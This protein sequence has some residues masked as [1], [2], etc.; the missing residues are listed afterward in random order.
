[1]ATEKSHELG[2]FVKELRAARQFSLGELARLAD[3]NKATLSRWEA[4]QRLPRLPELQAVM[5]ALGATPAQL[6]RAAALLDAPRGVRQLRA[7][8]QQSGNAF[9]EL[10]ERGP[11]GGDLL[12]AM[13]LRQAKGLE[14]VARAIGV[15]PS[16]LSRW[17]RGEVWP[18]TESLHRLCHV[19][20]VHEAEMVALTTGTFRTG[21]DGAGQEQNLEALAER[22]HIL[23]YHLPLQLEPLK[24]LVFF[25]LEAR[26]WP[27]A[28]H[29][30]KARQMLTYL[31]TI[32]AH[33]LSNRRRWAEIPP[34]VDRSMELA[35]LERLPVQF[36]FHAAMAAAQSAVYRGPQPTPARG[37]ALV[38]P[39]I[40]VSPQPALCAWARSYL[41]D[42]LNLAGRQ[43]EAIALAEEA[44]VIAEQDA[45]ESEGM[46]R[47]LDL[48]LVYLNAGLPASAL[49]ALPDQAP[50]H[51]NTQARLLM[52]RVKANLAADET[53]AAHASLQQV[54]A[55][56]DQ[57]QLETL[58]PQAEGLAAQL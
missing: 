51:P 35:S 26:I 29:Q 16:T 32:R 24:D 40:D 52:V 25:D 38:R 30:S 48:A 33:D 19:L 22:L 47:K 53:A 3:V 9:L 10:I 31:Y 36:A 34:Y 2:L 13:R 27:L 56:M 44:C 21:Y 23:M 5:T 41:A 57:H 43:E 4:G 15:Q 11:C 37:I 18:A 20:D 1:M 12:R 8:A 42:Y 58:R 14:E 55:L 54:Y 6:R 49:D 7:Y 46:L 50:E 28:V 39:W 45:N 17:E